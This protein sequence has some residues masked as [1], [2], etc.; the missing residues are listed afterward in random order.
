[1]ANY[2]KQDSEH[3]YITDHAEIEYLKFN[4]MRH[5]VL[6]CMLGDFDANGIYSISPEIVKEL[7]GMKKYLVETNE[8]VD[9]CVSELKLLKQISFLVTYEGNRATLSLIEKINFESNIKLNSGTYSNVNEFILDIVETT[10]EI[11]R[12]VIY[13]KWNISA[14]EG[15]VLDVFKMDEETLSSLFGIV[16]RFKY[17]LAANA[18]LLE[19]ESAIED[20]ES[21]RAVRMIEVISH[22]PKLK[23]AFDEQLRT[24]LSEKADFVKIDKPN[25]AKTLNEIIDNITTRNIEVLTE[26]E[27]AE[28]SEEKHNVQVDYS[29]KMQDVVPLK[30]NAEEHVHSEDKLDKNE[31]TYDEIIGEHVEHNSEVV[32]VETN[33]KETATLQEI[34]QDYVETLRQVQDK[35]TDRAVDSVINNVINLNANSQRHENESERDFGSDLVD[36]IAGIYGDNIENLVTESAREEINERQRESIKE[37]KVETVEREQTQSQ[38]SK[39][40]D[41]KRQASRADTP[42]NAGNNKRNNSG[43]GRRNNRTNN[44]R[45]SANSNYEYD[46]P[47]VYSAP[48][49]MIGAMAE[50]GQVRSATEDVGENRDF[51]QSIR[52]ENYE[53]DDVNILNPNDLA[54]MGGKF[55]DDNM[56]SRLAENVNQQSLDDVYEQVADS[57]DDKITDE[58][59]GEVVEDVGENQ[60]DLKDSQGE[61]LENQDELKG[62]P[63]NIVQPGL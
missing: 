5:T 39:R 28:F 44:N 17:L 20:V 42:W 8:N 48:T 54:N 24:V 56:I 16:N 1:M 31:Q 50:G 45:Q 61:V 21:E 4:N 18:V 43:G 36:L 14:F 32:V 46:G 47:V 34:S 59:E 33:G 9:L 37:D 12:N 25:F 57:I 53:N 63:T 19:Q 62:S 7:I 26:T 55:N 23:E 6:G 13:R 29:I 35:I 10:G 58:L 49:G 60:Q 41:K 27:Q 3:G 51:G 40:E 22:Y 11:D 15:E 38:D 30:V 52:E 2:L